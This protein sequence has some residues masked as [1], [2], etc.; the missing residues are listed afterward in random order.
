MSNQ[1]DLFDQAAIPG[2]V[3]SSAVQSIKVKPS[4]AQLTPAQHRFNK[5]IS[6][7][8]KLNRQMADFDQVIQRHRM[9][10]LQSMDAIE[11]RIS[12]CRR[13]ILLFLHER[14]QAKGLTA[15]EK[16][17]SFKLIKGLLEDMNV[18]G[19]A[20]LEA[21]FE[22][23]H[24]PE[25]QA[26]QAE[27]DALADESFRQLLQE[28]AGQPVPGLDSATSPEEMMAVLGA[29][30]ASK[31]EKLEAQR[32]AKRAKKPPTPR[33]IKA[34]QTQQ[35]ADSVIRSMFRQLASALHPDREPDAAERERKTELMTQVNT[36]Y[37]RRDLNTLLRLQMRVAQI[38][39][40]SIAK[41]TDERLAAMSTLLKEQVS[42]LEQA[43]AEAE[44]RASHDF[45]FTVSARQSEK[46]LLRRISHERG[47][48][49]ELMHAAQA[50][51]I[52]VRSDGGLKQWLKEQKM[53]AKQMTRQGIDMDEF[54]EGFFV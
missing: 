34:Q 33:Q 11:Q 45:G 13:E 6:R 50:D 44:M 54:M 37:E 43:L 30:M 39:E 29:H 14:R 15:S 28:L 1:F 16:K 52:R 49:E 4:A 5:L 10:Y 35:D 42:A 22:L 23:Y 26:Q 24:P 38:D 47:S 32:E 48:L 7:L 17:F 31:N 51:L 21:V 8:D 18:P 12:Q 41:L 20:E 46:D 9:P 53:Y 36:A 25:E 2:A 19:D 40:Q 3:K 27:A